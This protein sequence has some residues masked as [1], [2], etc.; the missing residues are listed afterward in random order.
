MHIVQVVFISI[1]Q[2]SN[3]DQDLYRNF[4]LVISDRWQQEIAETVFDAVNQEADKVEQKRRH[5]DCHDGREGNCTNAT[6]LFISL[7]CNC[8]PSVLTL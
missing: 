6:R 4:P 5:K 3:A 8:C 2:L 1:W 7:L